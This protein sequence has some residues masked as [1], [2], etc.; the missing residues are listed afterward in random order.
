[1]ATVRAAV[2]AALAL[3]AVI[4]R[5]LP[6]VEAAIAAAGLL[7]LGT[8]PLLVLDASFQLSFASVIALALLARR[9]RGAP[10]VERPLARASR[11]LGRGLAATAA[12]FAVTGPLCAHHFAELA[13]ASPLGN[14]LLVPLV[15]LAIVP[16]GLLGAA[17]GATWS[18][19]GLVPLWLAGAL[20]TVVLWLAELFRR[21]APLWRVWSPDGFEAGALALG[22]LLG[23]AAVS[24]R[25]RPRWLARAALLAAALGAGSLGTRALVQRLDPRLRV[26]FLDVGQGDATLIEG[27]RGYVALIDGGG[28]V[29]GR[30]DPGARVI[31]PVLRRKTIGR[32]DL[33]VLSHPHPD[34]M[35]GLFAILQRFPVG[36]LWTG[37]DG[38]GNPAYDQLLA[39]ARAR[40]VALPRPAPAARAGLVIQPRGP[41]TGDVIGVPPGL[42]VNDASLVV[43]VGFA[44]RW[45]LFPGDLEEQGEAELVARATAAD[46]LASD[47]LKVPHHGSRTSSSE[48]F[49]DAVR[50]RI[51][52]ASLARRNRFG[53]PRAEVV[54]RYR[55]RS[56]QLFRTDMQGAV[57]LKIDTKGA[58]EATSLRQGR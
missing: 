25:S 23:L 26:T 40:G 56:V 8:S 41:F 43:R 32:L 3:A 12:A 27:P 44:G 35:N 4:A 7:L 55:E 15:E 17:L 6:S 47:V 13:P 52:V 46:P 31:E 18:A 5:R 9:W 24:L 14:L 29:D 11:W 45:L 22:A 37:G 49:I 34:H 58:L 48:A 10:R 1:V 42:S 50:P 21:L 57:V 51:A 38:G 54:E 36:A 28:N 16:L 19:L 20:C 30:F 53:F 2:M 39:L 33:V